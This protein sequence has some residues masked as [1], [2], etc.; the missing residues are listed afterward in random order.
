M[1]KRNQFE[2]LQDVA[3]SLGWNYQDNTEEITLS[4]YTSFGQDYS[5]ELDANEDLLEQVHEQ[6]QNF[7]PCR[8]TYLWLDDDGH[9]KR[10]VPYYM[11]DVLK[12]MEEIDE[13]LE[14]LYKKFVDEYY[15][16]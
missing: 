1:D 8:E 15:E 5:F 13:A 14:T 2:K 4:R 12:D 7:D 11:G 16:I 10:G 9:G 6:W 3:E